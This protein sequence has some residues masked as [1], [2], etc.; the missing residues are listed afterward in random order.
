MSRRAATA[1]ARVA[2]AVAIVA[3]LLRY[4]PLDEILRV[5]R[6][7]RPAGALI[8]LALGFA[9]QWAIATRLRVLTRLEGM[10]ARTLDLLQ[11]NLATVFYG[12]WVPGG[13]VAGIAIRAF[14]IEPGR[15][16]RTATAAVLVLD[17]LVATWSLCLVGLV[18]YPWAGTRETR[19]VAAAMA[20]IVL[21]GPAVP[22]IAAAVARRMAPDRRGPDDAGRIGVLADVFARAR[23][24]SAGTWLRILAPSFV[25]HGLGLI[26]FVA[27][28]DAVGVGL[29]PDDAGWIRSASMLVALVPISLAG[30]GLREGAMIVLMTPHIATAA[31][32]VAFGWLSFAVTHLAAGVAGAIWEAIRVLIGPRRVG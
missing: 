15:G 20:V 1:A 16:G 23:A 7:T 30:I 10:R 12:L 14:R 22:A 21:L 25:A 32:A 24:W 17:R 29:A 5:L 6:S 4:V 8:A 9:T 19:P 2:V 26:A 18:L 11:I 3:L 31:E 28:A 27:A 13:N